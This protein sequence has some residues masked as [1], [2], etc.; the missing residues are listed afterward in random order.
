[1]IE[2]SK[3]IVN[4][5]ASASSDN[6]VVFTDHDVLPVGNRNPPRRCTCHALSLEPCDYCSWAP[7]PD[8][9]IP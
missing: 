5:R 1:M 9:S 4:K 2:P 3:E 7:D 8:W 6:T